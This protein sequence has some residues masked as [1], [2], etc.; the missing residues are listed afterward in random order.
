MYT[1]R[2]G[3][4]GYHSLEEE[5]YRRTEPIHIYLGGVSSSTYRGSRRVGMLVLVVPWLNSK[6]REISCQSMRRESITPYSRFYPFIGSLL[7]LPPLILTT[8]SKSLD[9]NQPSKNHPSQRK[10][11][12]PVYMGRMNV[13]Q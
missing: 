1:M 11:T 4:I 12:G 7:P 5:M 6:G 8:S 10:E 13:I 2:D 9:S 3:M